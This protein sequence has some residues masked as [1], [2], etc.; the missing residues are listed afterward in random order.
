[1]SYSWNSLIKS[2]NPESPEHL[3]NKMIWKVYQ[4]EFRNRTTQNKT[5]I[6]HHN[7]WW[8]KIECCVRLM[9]GRNDTP[10]DSIQT[11]EAPN[12]F[13][14]TIGIPQKLSI[15][16]WK[17]SLRVH[18]VAGYEINQTE[19]M[20]ECNFKTYYPQHH[21]SPVFLLQAITWGMEYR[22]EIDFRETDTN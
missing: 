17:L 21:F 1:M 14:R 15:I 4:N 6:I 9:V 10:S 8:D 20:V 19:G 18:C 3:N 11:N 2:F 5:A 16:P 13:I 7:S 22:K 12:Q